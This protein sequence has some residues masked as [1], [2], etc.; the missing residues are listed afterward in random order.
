[1]RWFQNTWGPVHT[2]W[3]WAIAISVFAA[4][5]GKG[6]GTHAQ[7]RD[8]GRHDQVLYSILRG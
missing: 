1:M 7:W 5:R 2:S 6:V 4:H 8:G 3:C